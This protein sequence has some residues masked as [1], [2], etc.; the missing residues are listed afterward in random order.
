ML[1][2]KFTYSY[3]VINV[4][5]LSPSKQFFYKLQK[6]KSLNP[7]AFGCKIV[8]YDI[9]NELVYHRKKVYAYELH[10]KEE[11]EK[12]RKAM[13]AGMPYNE[14]HTKKIELVR[15]SR[16]G[17]VA[18]FLEYFNWN[19]YNILDSV[20][21]N[22]KN[23]VCYRIN[24]LENHFQ[25]IDQLKLEDGVFNEN[26][27]IESLESWGVKPGIFFKDK[28]KKSGLSSLISN[29]KWYP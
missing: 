19:D 11:I 3:G 20:I 22:L 18:Y 15:W 17:N 6:P 12:G 23:R 4:N 27:T 5:T 2:E 25:I 8:F 16:Q 1:N 21:L 26:E 24:E 14:S 28:I 13:E 10:D 9:S 29:N 7:A